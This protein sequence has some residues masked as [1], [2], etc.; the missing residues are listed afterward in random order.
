[1]KIQIL[2]F[3]FLI[4]STQLLFSQPDNP[5]NDIIPPSPTAA[6]LGAYGNT[7]I[8][9]E[10]GIA[11]IGIELLD[12]GGNHLSVPISLNYLSSGLNVEQVSSWVGLGWSLIAGGVIT[13]TVIG[14]PDEVGFFRTTDTIPTI[15]GSEYALFPMDKIDLTHHSYKINDQTLNYDKI[16]FSYSYYHIFIEYGIV[17]RCQLRPI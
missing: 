5:I 10:S 15:I 8:S 12:F 7:D 2:F 17:S 14:D 9:P 4:V 6:A 3:N 11:N 1:M 16:C 13:R